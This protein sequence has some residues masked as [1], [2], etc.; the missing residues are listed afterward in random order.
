MK[1]TR[2]FAALAAAACLWACQ[3]PEAV[4]QKDN[5]TTGDEDPGT[6]ATLSI[7]ALLVEFEAD[8]GSQTLTVTTN[9]EDYSVSCEADWL[10]LDK[11]GSELTLT[12][13]AN[14]GLKSRSTTIVFTAGIM[15]SRLSVSQKASQPAPDPDP[16]PDPDP[17]PDPDPV[18]RIDVASTIYAADCYYYGDAFQNGTVRYVLHL[19][20]GTPENTTITN[21]EFTKYYEDYADNLDLSGDYEVPAPVE[22]DADLHKACSLIRGEMVEESPGVFTPTGTHIRYSASDIFL[23]DAIGDLRLTKQTDGKYTLKATLLSTDTK[24]E[25][26]TFSGESNEGIK[27]LDIPLINNAPLE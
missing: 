6:T 5:G 11:S 3:K 27:D 10:A 22:I 25:I 15:T 2:F 13:S 9:Q 1:T 12:A 24:H 21:L 17:N 23:C 18:D 14:T 19:Y 8:G 7:S 16:D 4:T 20:S 26:V